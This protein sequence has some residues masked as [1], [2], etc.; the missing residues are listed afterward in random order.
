[1]TPDLE[2]WRKRAIQDQGIKHTSCTSS[3]FKT[4]HLPCLIRSAKLLS[5]RAA[6]LRK[7]PQVN[8]PV[9]TSDLSRSVL[10]GFCSYG[11]SMFSTVSPCRS[12]LV[13]Q[14]TP[15]VT[16]LVKLYYF[17]LWETIVCVFHCISNQFYSNKCLF[18]IFILAVCGYSYL[19]SALH[20]A[21]LG[22]R[23]WKMG[24]CTGNP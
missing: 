5:L 4:W 22:N 18:S 20:L 6:V 3:L 23:S 8:I 15:P 14:Y 11:Q 1:M 24:L 16:I 17:C 9:M 2:K 19:Q 13:S 10:F 12:P 7:W 21:L